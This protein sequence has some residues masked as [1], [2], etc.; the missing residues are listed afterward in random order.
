MPFR[1]AMVD[2]HPGHP[3]KRSAT[4][5]TFSLAGSCN[6]NFVMPTLIEDLC[7]LCGSYAGDGIEHMGNSFKGELTIAPIVRRRG[8]LL[9]FIAR[10]LEGQTLQEEHT[11]I[12]PMM[13]TG[14]IGLWTLGS[15]IG[16]VLLHLLRRDEQLQDGSRAVTF[17]AGDPADSSAFREEITLEI[18]PQNQIGYRYAW[19]RPGGEFAPRSGVRMARLPSS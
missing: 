15:N 7:E 14:Q 12:A 11:V 1:A 8:V 16:S 5:L 10:S 9:L 3:E 19:G 4:W 18:C 17:G 6:R 13:G 2:G